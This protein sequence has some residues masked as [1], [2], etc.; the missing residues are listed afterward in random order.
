MSI[1]TPCGNTLNW[2]TTRKNKD[3]KYEF[4]GITPDYKIPAGETDWI[5]Y[6]RRL[7]QQ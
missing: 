2:T 1:K 6:T 5:E 7:L 3:R 4:V